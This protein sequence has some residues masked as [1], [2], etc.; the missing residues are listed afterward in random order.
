MKQYFKYLVLIVCLVLIVSMG[1]TT[2]NLWGKSK[3]IEDARR[4]VEELEKEQAE[5]LQIKEQVESPEFIEKE[6]REKLGL[7][8]Y[9]ES[10]VILPPEDVLRRLAPP[11]E[12]EERLED[13][14]IYKRWGRLFF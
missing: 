14:P 7:A 1:R 11:E 6:A 13:L 9:G 5:L 4:K 3:T 10:V 12:E 2:L 8:R